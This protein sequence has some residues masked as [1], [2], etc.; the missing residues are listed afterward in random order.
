[1]NGNTDDG[2]IKALSEMR[3]HFTSLKERYVEV[4]GASTDTPIYFGRNPDA[5]Q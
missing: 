4:V 3:E 1:L 5:L 2:S